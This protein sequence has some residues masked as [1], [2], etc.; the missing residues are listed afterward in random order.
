MDDR[1]I[2]DTR[3]PPDPVEAFTCDICGDDF[4][5]DAQHIDIKKAIICECCLDEIE[6]A[7]MMQRYYK[8]CAKS[9][10]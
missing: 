9:K 6:N 3:Q 4:P 8:K 10:L 2:E 5:I 1:D 7:R